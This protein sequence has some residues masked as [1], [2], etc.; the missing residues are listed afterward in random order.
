MHPQLLGPDGQPIVSKQ[1]TEIPFIRLNA[2]RAVKRSLHTIDRGA[3][4]Y[5]ECLPFLSRGGRYVCQLTPLGQAQLV[6]GFPVK[7]GAKDEL[8]LVAEVIVNNNPGEIHAGVDRLVAASIANMDAVIAG[9]TA[10]AET[11]Q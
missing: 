2:S 11:L 8:A 7:G 10:L 5:A 9:E 3:K 1:D 4:V 6:A